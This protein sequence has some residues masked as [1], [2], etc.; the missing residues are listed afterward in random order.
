MHDYSGHPGQAQLSRALA[1]R[2]YEVTHQHCP[3]YT[4]GRG[5]LQHETGDPATLTFEPVEMDGTFAKYSALTRF[6]QELRYGRDAARAIAAKDPA[7]AVISNVPLLA[8]SVL[9]RRL[10]RRGI[11][12]V[13]WHQDI[14][15]EAIGVAARRRI[16]VFGGLL[17]N[18][19]DRVERRIARRSV[20]V[21]AI[22]PTF[23][24]RL[25]E[26][27]VADKT[28]I[29]PNWAP[30]DELPVHR[31]DNPW[32][33]RAGLSDNLVVLYSGTLGL[34]HDPSIL[35][36]LAAGLRGSHP[37]ARV[38][39]VSEGKGRDWL[40]AHKAQEAAENLVLLDFQP[41]GDLPEMMASAD[42]LVAIL[43]PDASKFSVPSKVLTY[44]CSSRAVLG[45]L[46]PDNSVA[47]I[48]S[49]EEAG[50]VVDPSDR[51]LVV[52]QAAALLDDP[53]RRHA[54]GRSGRAYAERT[55]SPET[56]ADQF[57]GVFGD[58][59]AAPSQDPAGAGLPGGTTR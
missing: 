19:A 27:G 39:V 31:A 16:P 51:A 59:V 25:S 28:T 43:E 54:M 36:E 45:V 8:H 49:T 41:Y 42:L 35:A 52:K 33:Q 38:V 7:V 5:S 53:N 55:F 6:R 23:L 22:S 32:R 26:W 18:L 37:G 1:R 34:K 2:G 14:Y 46:P 47:E 13:F 17:A 44:L 10:A 9:A 29:V 24:E 30:I 3:S 15:S 12:M 4:T 57:L 20:A 40:E 56:A 58:L 50:V 48:L 21:V 11:P